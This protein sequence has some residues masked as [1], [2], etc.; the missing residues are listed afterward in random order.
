MQGISSPK[1][2]KLTMSKAKSS[3]LSSHLADFNAYDKSLTANFYN[4]GIGIVNF[5]KF[6]FL[7]NFM[8]DT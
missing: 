7:L 5:G 4:K 8:I 3:R 2:G 6:F 1:N